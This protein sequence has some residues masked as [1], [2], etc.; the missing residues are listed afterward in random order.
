[1]IAWRRRKE[2]CPNDLKGCQKN[3]KSNEPTSVRCGSIQHRR[4]AEQHSHLQRK[5]R[6]AVIPQ[7]E[8]HLAHAVIKREV[9]SVHDQVENPMRKDRAS[10]NQS[11]AFAAKSWNKLAD[12]IRT[13][14]DQHRTPSRLWV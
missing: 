3:N 4:A 1:M 13:S 5:G 7:S 10:H 6:A 11:R 8:S 14:A 2:E 12:D 9:R